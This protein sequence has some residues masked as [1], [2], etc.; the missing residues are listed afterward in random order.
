[1]VVD[2]DQK[3]K[4]IVDLQIRF[5]TEEA[6]DQLQNQFKQTSISVMSDFKSF[7]QSCG[8]HLIGSQVTSHNEVL[9]NVNHTWEQ[10][11]CTQAFDYD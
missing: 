10:A 7:E 11:W 2:V 8:C 6:V 3:P 5:L 4:I 1:M 9:S